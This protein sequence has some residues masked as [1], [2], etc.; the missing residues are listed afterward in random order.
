MDNWL[1]L[2]ETQFP[3]LKNGHKNISQ[4]VVRIRSEAHKTPSAMCGMQQVTQPAE[5]IVV[6]ISIW[7]SPN[8]VHSECPTQFQKVSSHAH[9]WASDVTAFPSHSAF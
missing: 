9:S 3:D 8:A 5:M 4:G 7:F 6:T 2:P 1:N